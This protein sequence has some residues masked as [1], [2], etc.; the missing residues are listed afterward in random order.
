MNMFINED[1]HPDP[2]QEAFG[3]FWNGIVAATLA[4]VVLAAATIIVGGGAIYVALLLWPLVGS[5]AFVFGILI[6]RSQ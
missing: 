2:A 1:E 4:S 5:M 3:T 6:P